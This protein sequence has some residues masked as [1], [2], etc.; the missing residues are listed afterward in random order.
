[1]I[2]ALVLV[3]SQAAAARP[4]PP[5]TPTPVPHRTPP[6]SATNPLEGTVR[7]NTGPRALGTSSQP[8]S[9]L[10]SLGARV[11]LN[12]EKAKTIFNQDVVPTPAPPDVAASTAAR[13]TT[14]DQLEKAMAED[15]EAETKWRQRETDRRNR[16]ADARLQQEEVCARYAAA[17][18]SAGTHDGY[19]SDA[20]GAILG[21]LRADCAIATGKADAIEAERE[22]LQEACRKTHGCKP[23]WLR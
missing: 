9:G 5:P 3:L 23:G 13:K 12:R 7:P 10:G 1:M 2:A 4:S 19:V 6:A 11:K 17:M 21:A 22:Q 16:L 15:L 14:S 8:T 20:A 18:N